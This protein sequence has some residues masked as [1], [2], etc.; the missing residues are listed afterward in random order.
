M[1]EDEVSVF[2]T[3]LRDGSQGRDISFSLEDKLK[4]ARRLD[5]LGVDFIEGGWVPSNPKDTKFFQ[6][7]GQDDLDN[8][9]L[10][11]LS[12][13]RRPG[14]RPEDDKNLLGLLDSGAP[15]TGIVGKSW[16]FHVDEVL[17]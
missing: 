5:D 15:V 6:K 9:R 1:K 3:T 17:G 4:I 13:T 11:A 16:R 8:A 14:T 7:F 12:S 2:D 10:V